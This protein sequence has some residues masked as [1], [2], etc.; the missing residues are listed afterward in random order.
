MKIGICGG[1]DEM[2]VM[3][4]IGYDF[5]EL[6]AKGTVAPLEDKEVFAK[7]L[8]KI[9][10]ENLPVVAFNNFIPGDLKIT[11]ENV[12]PDKL[13]YYVETALSR[14]KTIGGEVVVFGSG[15]AR[16][17]PEGFSRDKGWEQL[18]NF[19]HMTADIAQKNDVVIALEPLNSGETNIFNTF[20][21][22]LKM[23]KEVNRP[24]AIKILADLY[25][26]EKE[27]EPY[28]NVLEGKDW[29]AHVHVADTGRLHPGTGDYDYDKFISILKEINYQGGISIE[30]RWENK[31]EEARE[32]LDF[33]HKKL[34]E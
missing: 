1:I 23:V 13:K 32:A 2:S 30:C 16:R 8:K 28:E 15:G 10:K 14:V 19:L 17:I 34:K 5:M 11:G 18:K 6:S 29:L 9:K 7:H 22:G 20:E 4:E 21:E 12:N 26:V 3:E 31:E 25:H 27:N 33:L 24:E